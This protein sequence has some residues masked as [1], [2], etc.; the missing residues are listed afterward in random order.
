MRTVRLAGLLLLGLLAGLVL[1]K[2]LPARTASLAGPDAIAELV[3]ARIGGMTQWILI[4]GEDRKNPILLWLHGGPGSAQMPIHAATAGLERDFVVVH[5]DQRGA[6]KSNPR[7]FDTRTMTLRRYL[8]D[9]REVTAVLRERVGP[10]P[11][12]VL[13][14][15]WGTMLG[16]RLV[17]R[18]PEDYAGYVG[19]GQQ[20]DTMRG[21]ALAL[22]WLRAV[23]PD[24]PL[25]AAPPDAFRDHGRYVEL[26][27][28]LEAHGGGMN[29][30]LA[31]M[32]PR[33]LAAPEYRLPDYL[34]W[35]D[36]ASRGSG[37][38]WPDY[39]ERSLVRD[40][41]VMPVPMLL[42]AGARDLNTP[43]AL[44]EA[45]FDAVE[46]PEGKQ[47]VVFDASGHAPFLTETPLFEATVR[48]WAEAY[49]RGD[50]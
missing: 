21:A 3:P 48:A 39:R 42:I 35:L 15:S 2:S 17:A 5:W 32:L 33:A 45:W 14:H 28:A 38:M 1:W 6:G 11:V 23:A 34:R 13:G 31:S 47:M 29:V 20:V 8:A 4:R 40:V 44:V 27:Q 37:P 49:V 36:G 50:G 26:M 24:H 46:A 22:D 19:V 9:A 16:A 10:Q 30:S 41:P 18:W 12:I 25:A 7:G 43:T